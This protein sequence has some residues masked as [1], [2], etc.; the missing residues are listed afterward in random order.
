MGNSDLQQALINLNTVHNNDV[1]YFFNATVNSVDLDNRV[2]DCTS[3]EGR[4]AN[5]YP[6]CRLMTE[7]DD[8]ILIIPTIGSSV[9]ILLSHNTDPLIIGYS[10]VDQIIFRGGDLGGMVLVK[11][12]LT[13]LNNLEN[14]YND[15]AAKFNSH[16]HPI[17]VTSG[18]GS[19]LA[20]TTQETKTLTPTQQVD[21]ENQNI[22]QG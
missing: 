17:T 1:L 4:G 12:L 14:A 2:C 16:T 13:K 8:G 19:S 5:D 10:E 20:T 9:T 11:S 21:I 3:I 15:L 18:T 22:T 6:N 7:V